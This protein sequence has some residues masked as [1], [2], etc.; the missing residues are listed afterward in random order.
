MLAHYDPWADSSETVLLFTTLP[1]VDTLVE[2]VTA[3][4]Q[5]FH[6]GGLYHWAVPALGRLIKR[7]KI[8]ASAI[9]KATTAMMRS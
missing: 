8:A 6:S 1:P 7:V 5:K 9:P 3:L 2:E 4:L